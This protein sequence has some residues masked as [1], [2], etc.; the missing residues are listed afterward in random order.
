MKLTPSFQY[1]KQQLNW[2]LEAICGSERQSRID[3]VKSSLPKLLT[4][5]TTKNLLKLHPTIN[6]NLNSLNKDLLVIDTEGGRMNHF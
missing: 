3:P 4:A 2:A 1:Q 5:V 6:D